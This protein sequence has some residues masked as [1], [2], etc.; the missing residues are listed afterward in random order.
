M[1]LKEEKILEQLSPL[2]QPKPTHSDAMKTGS[3]ENTCS[4]A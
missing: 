4:G 3:A 2:Q 1:A